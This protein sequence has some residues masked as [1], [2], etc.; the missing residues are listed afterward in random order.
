M[1]WDV[2]VLFLFYLKE[3]ITT[4]I[5]SL[6][7]YMDR[8]MIEQENITSSPHCVLFSYPQLMTWMQ[9]SIFF[10]MS[11]HLLW[12]LSCNVEDRNARDWPNLFSNFSWGTKDAVSLSVPSVEKSESVPINMWDEKY[13]DTKMEWE[14]KSTH[15][16]LP[17]HIFV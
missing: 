8:I 1:F 5:V 10:N 15:L 17:T 4:T 9:S 2:R 7:N 3:K 16:S 13:K 11:K 12:P 14:P 6:T